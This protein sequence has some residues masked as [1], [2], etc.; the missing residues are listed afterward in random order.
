[1]RPC[2]S[3]VQKRLSQGV[4]ILANYTWSHCISDIFDTQ[5][6]AGGASAAA[7]PGNRSAYH[8][9]C[10]TSDQRHLFNLSLVAQTPT[11]SNRALRLVAT[12]WQVSTILRLQS[13]R[14][15][16][17]TSGVDTALSGQGGQTANFTGADPYTSNRNACES[18]VCCVDG[19]RERGSLHFGR[20]GH[21]W[22]S[23][24]QQYERPGSCHSRHERSTNL[25]DPRA[26]G[27]SVPRG[28]VQS[29]QSSEFRQSGPSL[30]TSS[31]FGLITSTAAG[32]PRIVQ[33]AMKLLF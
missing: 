20:S 27:A 12:G 14:E 31:S 30:F 28:S 10:G 11:F 7:I 26:N 32:D 29:S 9:N 16:T 5:T 18:A 15:F 22:Q 19:P 8:G 3:R 21:V 6:G 33:L 23:G 25:P 2:S 13:A 17:V 24:L 4:S 1:M